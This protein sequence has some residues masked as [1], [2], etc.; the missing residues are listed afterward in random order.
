MEPRIIFV[1]TSDL[2]PAPFNPSIRTDEKSLKVLYMSMQKKGFLAHH[3]I[4]IV[5]GNTIAD[6]HRRWTC[7]KMLNIE[8]VPCIVANESLH[9]V[10]AEN[11]SQRKVN[12]KE[13]I[14]ALRDGLEVVPDGQKKRIDKVIDMIGKDGL[15]LLADKNLSPRTVD[16]A[17]SVAKYCGRKDD[18]IF[19]NCV[20]S[21]FVSYK[22]QDEVRHLMRSGIP[23]SILEEKV[24]RNEKLKM[25][26][27]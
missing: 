14:M 12:E 27:E 8:Q 25:W 17:K 21:W 13:M 15:K 11:G 9:E 16:A 24:T 3:P 23:P 5:G 18:R 2:K 19:I 7:A 10:W 22:C 26:S 6:G 20:V 1:K 4:I